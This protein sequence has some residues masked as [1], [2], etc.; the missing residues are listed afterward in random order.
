M[1][2]GACDQT[3]VALSVGPITAVLSLVASRA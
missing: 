3:P 2:I 1:P